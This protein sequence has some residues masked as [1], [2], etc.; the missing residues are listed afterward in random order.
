MEFIAA[1]LVLYHLFCQ[2][3]NDDLKQAKKLKGL[4]ATNP[5]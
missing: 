3:S 5:M 1:P 2:Q 4:N